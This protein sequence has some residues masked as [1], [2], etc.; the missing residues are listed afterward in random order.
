MPKHS[1]EQFSFATQMQFSWKTP[2]GSTIVAGYA[3]PTLSREKYNG[4]DNTGIAKTVSTVLSDP[5]LLRQ[6]TERVY[7]L[8]LKDLHNQRERS[9]NYGSF[10]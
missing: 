9:R 6:L 2:D 8:M 1:S 10:F 7:K 4:E 3:A 5:M